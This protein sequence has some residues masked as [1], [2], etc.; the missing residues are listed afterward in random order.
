MKTVSS[1]VFIVFAIGLGLAL[2]GNPAFAGE[3][4]VT[5]MLGGNFCGF[6]LDDVKKAL[7]GVPGVTD[8][9]F[10]SSQDHAYVTGDSSKM[11]TGDLVSAVDGVKGT[12]W[13]CTGKAVP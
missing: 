6:Y 1:W 12:G 2:S 9:T 8:V 11:K 4:K 13:F 10:S 7:M 3:K 5:L